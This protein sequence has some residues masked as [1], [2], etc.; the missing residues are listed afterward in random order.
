M[1]RPLLPPQARRVLDLAR[2]DRAAATRALAELS[3]DAQVALVC[4]TP[5]ARR[6]ELLALASEPEAVIPRLPEAEL[7]FTLKAAGLAD[8]AWIL[9]QASPEQ[10]VAC[11]DLDAWRAGRP[12]RAALGAWLEAL[13]EAGD[14]ALL[15]GVRAL[16]PE[17][18]VLLLRS[19]LE[20]E[21]RPSGD[22]GWQPP[23]GAHTLEGQ[24][25]LLPLQPGDDLAAVLRMLQVLLTQ[26][27][28]TYFRLLQGVIHELELDC[29]EFALRWRSGLL[30]DLGF[31]PW[32][33]AL[34]IYGTLRPAERAQVPEEARALEVEPWRLPVWIPQLPLETGSP[35]SVFRAIAAL[36]EEERRAAFYALVGLAN[37]VAVADGFELSDAESS[38]RA[39]EKAARFASLG[40][41]FVAGE[42][43]LAPAEVMRRVPLQRLF[44]VGAN[45]DPAAAKPPLREAA[46]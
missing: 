46:G 30:E 16:D 22:D 25:Y 37:K 4:E 26:D 43:G 11:V 29:E 27:Y 41:D 40:L 17:L 24:F 32:E 18:L 2:R 13:A 20:V 14:E 36:S 45:L 21:M 19:R 23:E 38:P 1:L 15:L 5:L 42:R 3:L 35:H 44:S 7:C 31:P 39:I 34:A 8:S 12:D 33:E 10:L 6:A 9:A 28:W